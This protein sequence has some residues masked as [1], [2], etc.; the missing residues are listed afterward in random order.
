MPKALPDSRATAPITRSLP[1]PVLTSD[2]KIGLRLG[3]LVG[4]ELAVAI[5]PTVAE[6]L[7]GVAHFA[8][9]IQIQVGDYDGILI[10][11]RLRDYLTARIAEVTLAVELADVPGHFVTHAIYRAD[12]ITVSDG[13]RRLFQLPKI[14]G[15]S[16]HGG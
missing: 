13:V 12:K 4:Y 16:G 2:R 3:H 6:E 11:R 10:A 9:Q 14:F 15:Q 1:L 5:R 8:D 7:P